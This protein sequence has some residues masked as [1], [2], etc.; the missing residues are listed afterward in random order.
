MNLPI[1]VRPIVAK[2]PADLQGNGR[3]AFKN[4]TQQ[5]VNYPLF[6]VFSR[7][8]QEIVQERNEP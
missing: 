1:S 6:A 2:L 3:H 4:K 5:V 8:I 7:F